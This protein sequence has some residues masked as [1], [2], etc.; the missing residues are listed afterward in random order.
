MVIYNNDYTEQ[1]LYKALVKRVIIQNDGCTEKLS[2]IA[3]IIQNNNNNTEQGL[4]T[5]LQN[6]VYTDKWSYT[7]G[8][9]RERRLYKTMIIQNN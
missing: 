6:H 8:D 1:W 2:Y 3:M 7:I 9:Y 4:A 5:I